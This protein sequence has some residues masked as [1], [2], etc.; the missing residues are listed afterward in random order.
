MNKKMILFFG[1]G[2]FYFS[3]VLLADKTGVGSERNQDRT[4]AP[5]SLTQQ[6]DKCHSGGNFNTAVVTRL[7]DSNGNIVNEYNGGETYTY[8]VEVTGSGS[9]FGFQSVSLKSNNT[10]GGTFTVQSSNAR[11]LTMSNKSFAEHN[12]PSVAGLFV[13]NWV[14]PAPGS[15]TITFYAAGNNVNNNNNDNGDDP[16]VAPN[17]VITESAVSSVENFTWEED[18]YVF[19]NPAMNVL[20]INLPESKKVTVKILDIQGKLILSESL[21]NNRFILDISD[22]G[23][24]TYLIVMEGDLNTTRKFFIN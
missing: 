11:V 1:L 14:A 24:G 12:N 16:A 15:G 20:N 22:L 10:N 7:K 19:P 4:G 8:E 13:M 9:R 17:L 5:G 23:A 6:C 3:G 21:P 2:I 18:I